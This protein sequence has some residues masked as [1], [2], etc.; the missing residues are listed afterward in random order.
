MQR[1]TRTPPTPDPRYCIM[2]GG[3]CLGTCE[4][5]AERERCEPL[6]EPEGGV[7]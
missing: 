3:D 2:C 1:E 4:R 6:Q 5:I 7:E